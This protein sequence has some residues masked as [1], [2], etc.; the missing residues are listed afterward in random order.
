M[1]FGFSKKIFYQKPIFT[2]VH[3]LVVWFFWKL[4]VFFVTFLFFLMASSKLM[5]SLKHKYINGFLDRRVNFTKAVISE[6]YFTP[7]LQ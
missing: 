3:G 2:F 5:I 6:S 1:A 7:Q 4:K